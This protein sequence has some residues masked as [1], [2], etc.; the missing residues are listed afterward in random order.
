MKSTHLFFRSFWSLALLTAGLGM[1]NGRLAQSQN[2]TAS[3]NVTWDYSALAKVPARA[4]AQRNPLENDPEAV[5][6]GRKLFADHCSQCHGKDGSGDR[7][8]P[9]LR[10]TA[11]H[12]PVPGA[13][14][15]VL[16]N[17][18]IRRG[19][20]GWSKLPEPQRWQLVS[21]L[22]SLRNDQHRPSSND[23]AQNP[24]K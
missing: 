21:F 10:V 11:M 7:R 15:Y 9:D 12:D 24:L 5:A 6:A 16:T 20:P 22:K 8:G 4:R 23:P 18:V 14:F 3:R 1:L 13:I 19:M 2:P 17:G